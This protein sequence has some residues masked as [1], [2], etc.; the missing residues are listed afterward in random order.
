MCVQAR[1]A[2]VAVMEE[3]ADRCDNLVKARHAYTLVLIR[4]EFTVGLG[5]LVCVVL[6]TSLAGLQRYR[7]K[8]AATSESNSTRL[9]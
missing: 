7:R 8:N 2:P 1:T 4:I 5:G 9:R 3:E 6:A